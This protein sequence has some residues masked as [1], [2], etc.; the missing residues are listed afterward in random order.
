MKPIKSTERGQALVI[1]AL[2]AMVLFGFVALAIDGSAKFSDRRHAQNAAD[3]AALAGALA[4]VNDETT[5]ITGSLEEWEYKALIRAEEN[6][7]D[8]FATNDVWVFKCNEAVGDRAGAPVDCGPYENDPNY[9][10]VVILSHI[11]TTF[12]RVFGWEQFDNLVSSV[13]YW[14]KRGPAYD[15]NLVVALNPNPCTGSNG[16]VLFTG[17]A[18]ITLDG[19]GAFVNS[20][21]NGCGMEHGG[22]KCPI[23]IDGGLG[24]TGTGNIDMGSCSIPAPAYIQDA[25]PFPPDM[26]DV[27]T[28][29]SAA[30]TTTY[31]SNNG[32]QVTTLQPGAYTNFP[33]SE[34][35]NGPSKAK[36]YDNIVLDDGIYCLKDG[37][38]V[39]SS[40]N[41]TGD[42]V[43]LY[44]PSNEDFDINGGVLTLS[45]RTEGDYAG[46]LIIVGSTF[47]GQSPKCVLNG[48][49]GNSFTGTIFAPYCELTVTGNSDTTS[50]DTQIIGYT[51]TINGGA[52]ATLYYDAGNNAQSAP[53]IGLMR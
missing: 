36:L 27:P 19:G 39:T 37:L 23:I 31:S 47:S 51:V 22:S 26:P 49:A 41:I 14:N 20:G 8:D 34:I 17:S 46:Y 35:K 24:S 2:S 1:I 18:T 13:T 30:T 3:T 12:A 6:G 5:I 32:T 10:A 45:G 53:K 16:N 21:G 25:Y 40:L 42:N 15:G 9:V 52:N 11:D 28:I 4:L 38:K 7:Y 44:I 43:L 33:P 50:F 29:C 48:N